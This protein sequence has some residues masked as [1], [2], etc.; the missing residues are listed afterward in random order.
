MKK[1]F[2]LFIVS[3]LFVIPCHAAVKLPADITYGNTERPPEISEWVNS[4]A[5]V[6]QLDTVSGYKG[7]WTERT[8][9]T[10][11]G[12]L[13]YVT[14]ME[15]KGTD[16]WAAKEVTQTSD[17]DGQTS[18]VSIFKTI[19]ICGFAAEYELRPMLGSSI[20]VKLPEGVLTVEAKRTEEPEIKAVTERLIREITKK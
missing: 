17:D 4:A 19:Y 14:W 1:I 9:R 12:T 3:T 6:T 7:S 2:M 18:E 11:H 5:R 16:G 15:G 13:F 10:P 8:Y 20:V